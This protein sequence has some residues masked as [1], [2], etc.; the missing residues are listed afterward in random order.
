MLWI[1]NQIQRNALDAEAVEHT[2]TPYA[3]GYVLNYSTDA[4]Y[5]YASN[6]VRISSPHSVA[7]GAT[8]VMLLAARFER[9]RSGELIR[10]R[11]GRRQRILLRSFSV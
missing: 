4:W 1:E 10:S 11:D 5:Q 6:P 9:P 7:R 8:C 3:V 2:V